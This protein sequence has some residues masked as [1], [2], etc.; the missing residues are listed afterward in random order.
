[1]TQS[2]QFFGTCVS[3]VGFSV[4]LTRAPTKVELHEFQIDYYRN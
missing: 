2:V 3:H 1:M 4:N